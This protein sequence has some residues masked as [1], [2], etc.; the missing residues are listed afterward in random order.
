M[1]EIQCR[2]SFQPYYSKCFLY[3]E[4]LVL[5]SI[6]AKLLEKWYVKVWEHLHITRQMRMAVCM[7]HPQKSKSLQPTY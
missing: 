5:L 2:S 1:A 7:P 4:V 3:Q 6:N